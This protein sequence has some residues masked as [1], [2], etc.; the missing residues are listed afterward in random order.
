MLRMT[1]AIAGALAGV[2][3]VSLLTSCKQNE[4][5]SNI[6]KDGQYVPT[7][8]LELTVWET[9]GTDY[10]P[11]PV[12][13]GDLVAEWLEN[14]TKVTVKNMYG[15][16][17]GQWDPKLTKLVAGNNLPHIVHCGAW[18]GPAHF[19]KLDQLGQ[20]WELTPELIQK[21][22]PE[23]WRRTPAKY[24]ERMKVNGKLL[25]IPYN[26][27]SER[28]AYPD[29]DDET[30][31]FIK[32]T[33]VAYETDVTY[34]STKTLWIRDDIL[35][36]FY[37]EAKSYNELVAL[38]EE[39]NEP[40]GDELLDIPIKSTQEFID[41]MYKIKDANLKENGK[42][43]YAFGYSGGDNWI[44]LTWLGADMYG[45]K[46]HCYTGTWN[47]VKQK[48]EVPLV[49]DLVKQ[50][51]RT[52]TQMIIDKVIDPESLTHT[53]ALYKEK[54]LNGQYAIVPLTFVDSPLAI[55][56]ELERAGKSF[57][58]RPFITQVP[59]HKEYSPFTEERLWRESICLLKTLS[60]EEM[61]QVLNW[62]N[63][64]YTDEYEQVLYW[65]PKEAGL[66][67]ETADGKRQFT[68]ERFTRYFIYG[69]ASALP[70]EEDR[71]GLQGNGGL[72]SVRPAPSSRWEPDVMHRVVKYLPTSDSGFKFKA[73]SEHVKNVKTYPPCQA[74]ASVY[75]EVPQVVKFWAER[76]QW[77]AKFKMAMASGSL[78]EFEQK[79]QEA[80]DSLNKIV[81]IEDMENAMT[82]IAKPLAE[83]LNQ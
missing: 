4:E 75:A 35:K 64:Q 19:A 83:Q 78:Q 54:I 22:A 71:K 34:L 3:L 59:A 18:Q 23:V 81:N 6:G 41:F 47:D 12:P 13:K 49:H 73:T 82:A 55:N 24:W 32:E 21:Y 36:M 37:P 11:K 57:R 53:V 45:Y 61:I 74:W 51:A 58:F 17:G 30:F 62:I 5:V 9:Q 38:L 31:E 67:T 29:M 26:A 43:V 68:D 8:K 69:D 79:W 52:Q 42:T 27:V 80:V 76:E 25:G 60:E 70:N 50:A 1:R 20:V 39:R 56:E 16:D 66:Y 33:T 63:T 10:A 7:K 65:G 48:I 44:A 2:L 40:I 46:N 77:E 72:M 14:K 28:E 15:N